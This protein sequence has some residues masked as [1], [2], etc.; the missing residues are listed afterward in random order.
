MSRKGLD[1]SCKQE[2]CCVGLTCEVGSEVDK[3]K[4]SFT[5]K[6]YIGCQHQNCVSE[7]QDI[8]THGKFCHTEHGVGGV[9]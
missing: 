1:L 5:L 9:G 7:T 3:T 8:I 6:E 4:Q 2:N